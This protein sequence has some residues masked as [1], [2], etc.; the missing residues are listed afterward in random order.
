MEMMGLRSD[1][2]GFAVSI[3]LTGATG[4][5]G[6]R[7]LMEILRYTDAECQ[8]LVR[9]TDESRAQ[10]RIGRIL[11]TYGME[12]HEYQERRGRIH[13]VLG[14]ITLDRFG[15][16]RD[17]YDGLARKAGLVIHMA[18]D[19]NL[20]ASYSKLHPTNVK[21]TE[22]II[23]FC[24]QSGCPLAHGSTYGV[25]GDKVY[26]REYVFREEELYIGQRFPESHYSRTK[27]EAEQKVHEAGS[28]GLRWTILRYGDVMGDSRSG[29]YPLN[30]KGSIGLY[31]DIFK[32]IVETGIAP[33]LEDRLYITPVDFAAR[34]T[35][36]LAMN[37]DAYR[38]TFH[39]LNSE[40]RC[41]YHII[42]LL[43]ECGYSLRVFPAVDYKQ[44]FQKNR[45]WRS[46]K[47][48]RSIFTR[49]VTGFPF[50]PNHVE[51][52]LVSVHEAERLLLAAGIR[53]ASPDYN[54]MATYLNFCI[55]SGYL[56]SPADQRPLAEIR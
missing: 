36:Y 55:R 16:N 48:Y 13:P 32:T 21:G 51:S 30:G 6:G 18:A 9:A 49:L 11:E 1:R 29:A 40:Q 37:P 35:L 54:L 41:F 20:L 12:E 42:N 2:P 45:V 4:V 33:F 53:C 34:A 39:I 15:L 52:A 56:P 27:F 46:G 10:E 25:I 23:E 8:C 17:I 50:L 14:D 43:V 26:R 28:R 5:V 22:H 24:L 31:Y 7:I 44:L 47:I 38:S 3:F 19:T